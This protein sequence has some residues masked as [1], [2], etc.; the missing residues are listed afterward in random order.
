M[1]HGRIGTMVVLLGTTLGTTHTDIGTMDFTTVCRVGGG[2]IE[3]LHILTFTT[4]H[5][6]V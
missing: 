6:T 1:T 3:S 4:I 2:Y 5:T